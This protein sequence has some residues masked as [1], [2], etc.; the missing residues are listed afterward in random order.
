MEMKECKVFFEDVK[1]V[2]VVVFEEGVVLGGGV[3]LIC[4]EKVFDFLIKKFEGDVV[5]GMKI[6]C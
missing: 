2:I 4:C 5:L 1:V 3:V 6:I